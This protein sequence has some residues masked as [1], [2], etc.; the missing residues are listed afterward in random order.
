MP[1]RYA[2]EV[3]NFVDGRRTAQ[4]IR[5]AVSAIYGPI[6]LDVVVEYLR[7]LEAIRVVEAVK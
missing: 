7:A 1:E 3:L 4:D 5:A 2:Y 6:P